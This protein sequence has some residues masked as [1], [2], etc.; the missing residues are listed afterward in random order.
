MIWTLNVVDG[1]HLPLVARASDR[2]D[3]L[4]R[5]ADFRELMKKIGIMSELLI[6]TQ[7]VVLILLYAFDPH[8][9]LIFERPALLL[10]GL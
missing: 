5:L 4:P 9:F 7:K 2:W 3:Q 8:V 10:R 1:K 6:E